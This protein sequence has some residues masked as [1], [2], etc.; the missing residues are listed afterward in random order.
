MKDFTDREMF[1][2]DKAF[3]ACKYYDSVIDWLTETIDDQGH[4]VSQHLKH[5]ADAL[6]AK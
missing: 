6:E 4:T 3:I 1:L 5:D 2:M